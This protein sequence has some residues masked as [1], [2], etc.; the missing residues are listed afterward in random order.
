MHPSYNSRNLDNDVKLSMPASLNS[1]M[2]TVV[3]PCRCASSGT[4][5]MGQPTQQSL[6]P[7][8]TVLPGSP[9]PEQRQQHLPWTD[10]LHMF[11]AGFVDGGKDSCQGD[12]GVQWAAAG[13]CVLGLQ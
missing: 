5:C 11:C 1:Y 6:L 10:Q 3:M 12:R 2:C 7:R 13:C 9:H 8:P 4:H